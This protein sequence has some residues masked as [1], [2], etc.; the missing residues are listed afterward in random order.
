[1]MQAGLIDGADVT[2][3]CDKE[4]IAIPGPLTWNGHEFLD[5]A[6]NEGVWS[7]AKEKL[8]SI[9]GDVPLDVVKA[10]LIEITK[11]QLGL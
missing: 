4:N 10:V 7:K 6:R 1:M 8:K 2:S 11:R 5:A 9:G 3:Q